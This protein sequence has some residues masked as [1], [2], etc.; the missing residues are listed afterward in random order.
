MRVLALLHLTYEVTDRMPSCYQRLS[1][2]LI[3]E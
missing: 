3:I 1:G 2:H